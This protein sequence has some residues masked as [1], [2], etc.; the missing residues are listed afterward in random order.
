MKD[1]IDFRDILDEGERLLEAGNVDGYW[2]LMAKHDPYAEVAGDVAAGR[3]PMAVIAKGRL[4]ESFV[5]KH[6]RGPTQM[7]EGRLRLD[8]AN[9]DLSV[10]KI[11]VAKDGDI[12]VTSQQTSDYHGNALQAI[13]LPRGTYTPEN[14]Q[15]VMAGFWS[16]YTGKPT[17]DVSGDNFWKAYRDHKLNDIRGFFSD[18]IGYIRDVFEAAKTLGKAGGDLA[19]ELAA[20]IHDGY[21]I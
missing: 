20:I 7:E 17:K 21:R 2:K 1:Q 11:N 10:R 12:R 4:H 18:P 14:L 8:I 3:G 5:K 19:D 6:G 15:K 16:I 13:G 9:R